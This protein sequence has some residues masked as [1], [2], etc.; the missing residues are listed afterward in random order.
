MDYEKHL[1]ATMEITLGI[2]KTKAQE[3]NIS[4]LKS[5]FNILCMLVDLKLRMGLAF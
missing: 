5:R 4:N 1:N 3:K 2:Q